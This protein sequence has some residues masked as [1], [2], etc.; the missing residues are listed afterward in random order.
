MASG[1][2]VAEALQLPREPLAAG[3]EGAGQRRVADA[4]EVERRRGQVVVLGALVLQAVLGLLQVPG[5]GALGG[6]AAAGVAAVLRLGLRRPDADRL[7]PVARRQ[8][9]AVGA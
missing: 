4:A 6:G 8:P 7:V 1:P 3:L 9:L 5:A 2:L